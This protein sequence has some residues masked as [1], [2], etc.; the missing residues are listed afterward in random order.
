[1]AKMTELL[2]SHS[3]KNKGKGRAQRPSPPRQKS[4]PSTLQVSDESVDASWLDRVL[5]SEEEELEAALAASLSS[6]TAYNAS[7]PE[8]SSSHHIS[9][10]L[11]TFPTAHASDNDS[12]MTDTPRAYPLPEDSSV[13]STTL[14]IYSPTLSD[15][16]AAS[17][18]DH[19]G[20]T[21]KPLLRRS[22]RSRF[23]EIATRVIKPLPKQR[24]P[25]ACSLGDPN[26]PLAVEG[27]AAP[28]SSTY[29]LP[30]PLSNPDHVM[31]TL[32]APPLPPP[33]RAT[34]NDIERLFTTPPHI[35]QTLSDPM[36]GTST[37]MDVNDRELFPKNSS[38]TP[39][40]SS[41]ASSKKPSSPTLLTSL[42]LMLLLNNLPEAT[43]FG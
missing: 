15:P 31:T 5:I 13:N 9:C 17:N 18:L 12:L 4:V 27:S 39:P 41:P 11:Q 36:A 22:L 32:L 35:T 3:N 21:I 10:L 26:Q 38:S 23:L 19:I 14:S 16:D 37:P 33:I 43:L 29:I 30:S 8:S 25:K 20:R 24:M 7:A 34:N 42:P 1:M 6:G 28:S 40:T 2:L